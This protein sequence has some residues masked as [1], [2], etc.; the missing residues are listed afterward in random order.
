MSQL[1]TWIRDH[2]MRLT[3][4]M[5]KYQDSQ[6][7]TQKFYGTIKKWERGYKFKQAGEKTR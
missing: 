6:I 3:S 7:S 2:E 1:T 4:L 5:L